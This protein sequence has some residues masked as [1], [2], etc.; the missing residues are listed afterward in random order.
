MTETWNVNS[1]KEHTDSMLALFKEHVDALLGEHAAAHA[2]R[3]AGDQT[4]VRAAFDAQEKVIRQYKEHIEAL[5]TASDRAV[6][7]AF[8]AQKALV[9]AALASIK[10]AVTKAEA[11]DLAKFA[12]V[13][14]MRGMAN[15]TAARMMPRME[16]TAIVQATQ[17]K[18]D[19]MSQ[20]IN[21]LQA[22]IDRGEGRGSG[23]QA[24]WGY[25]VG[26]VGLFLTLLTIGGVILAFTR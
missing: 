5:F 2:E 22:R 6:T 1:L 14:E 21:D 23:L 4:A 25:L 12:A 11:S 7:A 16:H 10:E 19:A 26:G 3:H 9:D 17:E 15:D 13:N 20:R 18:I 8:A 24:G